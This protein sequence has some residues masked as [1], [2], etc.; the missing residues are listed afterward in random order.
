MQAMSAP[1]PRATACVAALLAATALAAPSGPAVA[2]VTVYT[3]QAAFLAAIA[4]GSYMETFSG[5]PGGAGTL[6]ASPLGFGGGGYGFQANAPSGL[7]TAI[8]SGNRSLSLNQNAE[9]I[10]FTSIVGPGAVTAIGGYFFNTNFDGDAL[11]VGS[12]VVVT[13]TAGA[14]TET[15][16][17]ASPTSLTSFLGFVS[18]ESAFS[19]LT[20]G[21]NPGGIFNWQTADDLIL[22][23]RATLAVVAEP[24]SMALFGIGLLG[25]AGAARTR[26]ATRR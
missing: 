19:A 15:R 12:S 5:L 1:T 21:A 10:T 13:A 3:S 25:L 2:A 18:D 17:I 23:A 4:P 7:V 11:A 20:I 6:S 26:G 8:V 22:G 14:I 9:L 24:V 16:S